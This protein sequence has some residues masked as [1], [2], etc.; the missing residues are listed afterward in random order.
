MIFLARLNCENYLRVRSS[1]GESLLICECRVCCCYRSAMSVIGQK[2]TNSCI[3]DLSAYPRYNS[4]AQRKDHC[5][6]LL[7]EAIQRKVRRCFYKTLWAD[8]FTILDS[9][10]S[11]LLDHCYSNRFFYWLSMPTRSMVALGLSCYSPPCG[12]SQKYQLINACFRP[13]VALQTG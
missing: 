10:E 13:E 12:G 1:A 4:E 9:R 3:D 5:E 11:C 8:I 6:A 7:Q 2:R